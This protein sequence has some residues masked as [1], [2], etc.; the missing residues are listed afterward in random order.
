MFICRDLK[1]ERK[2]KLDERKGPFSEYLEAPVDL[3]SLRVTQNFQNRIYVFQILHWH[4]LLKTIGTL[5]FS[6]I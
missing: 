6:K 3:T 4:R 2:G 5:S 1:N